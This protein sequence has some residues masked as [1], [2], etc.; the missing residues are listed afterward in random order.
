MLKIDHISAFYGEFQGLD[1]ITMEVRSEKTTIVIGPNGAGKTTLLSTISGLL[2]PKDGSIL[3]EKR[4][5]EGKEAYQIAK[6][7]IAYVPEGGKVF[8]NLTVFENLKVG[9]YSKKAR[10]QLLNSL[11]EVYD[12]FP[13]LK[14]R[15]NQQA[16]LMS[17]GERQML[18]IARSLM[19]RPKLI[20]L[21]EPSLGLAPKVVSMVFDFVE[22]LKQKGYT[23]LVVEQNAKKALQLA[24]YA[25]LIES[26]KVVFEG[27]KADFDKN[28][29]IEKAYL[30][31]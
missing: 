14:D 21:D 11:E 18:A 9:A 29:Y 12:L 28:P 30:G 26:G 15:K 16:G 2:R 6:M 13:I 3:F 20:L 24:D 4:P 23:V 27:G 7:G 5:I 31:L 25:Y 8:P 17:G 10:T 1:D 22:A 19:S